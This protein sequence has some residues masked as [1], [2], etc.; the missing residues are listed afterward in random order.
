MTGDEGD[1]GVD[2]E[3]GKDTGEAMVEEDDGV[4]DAAKLVCCDGGDDDAA[5]YEEEIDTECAVLEGEHVIGGAVFSFDAVEVGQ[6]DEH[7]SQ[8]TAD[9]DAYDSRWLSLRRL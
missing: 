7:G 6:H 5:D 1:G 3:D 2:P 8:A 9:L 4:A